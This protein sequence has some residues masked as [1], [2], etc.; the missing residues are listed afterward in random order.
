MAIFSVWLE[1]EATS[2]RSLLAGAFG[3]ALAVLPLLLPDAGVRASELTRADVGMGLQATDLVFSLVKG[4]RRAAE[5]ANSPTVDR[6]ASR[7]PIVDCCRS[8]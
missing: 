3:A 6:E 1:D 2:H 5:L 4:E 8:S 7:S